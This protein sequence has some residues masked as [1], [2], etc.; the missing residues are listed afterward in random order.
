MAFGEATPVALSGVEPSRRGVGSDRFFERGVRVEPE[1]LGLSSIIARC[2]IGGRF[3]G[4][5]ESALVGW[6]SPDGCRG[7]IINDRGDVELDNEDN[8]PVPVGV[9]LAVVADPD[10]SDRDDA[11]GCTDFPSSFIF[12]IEGLPN[13]FGVPAAQ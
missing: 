7:D 12:G 4:G 2:G 10:R 1:P 6:L 11:E 5:R 8:V 13:E 9:E 3:G